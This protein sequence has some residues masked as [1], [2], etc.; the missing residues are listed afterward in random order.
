MPYD[1]KAITEDD[2]TYAYKA[3]WAGLPLSVVL[4]VSMQFE[5]LSFLTI[6]AGGFVSGTFVAQAWN[7]SYDEFQRDEITFASGW[8]LSL[9]GVLLFLAI[10]PNAFRVVVETDLAIASMA[11]LF[12]IAIY[13]R[14][15]RNGAFSRG[16]R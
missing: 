12:H 11:L 16:W 3:M 5:A 2:R 10:M 7:W 6:A 15:I 13:Y 4:L 9:A 14:R 1:P 8:A